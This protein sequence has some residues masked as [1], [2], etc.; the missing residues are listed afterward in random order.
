MFEIYVDASTID[1]ISGIGVIGFLNNKKV[2][3]IKRKIK[4]TLKNNNEAE[5]YAILIAIRKIQKY[6]NEKI[7]IYSDSLNCLNMIKGISKCKRKTSFLKEIQGIANNFP[8]LFFSYIESNKNPAHYVAQEAL[9]IK[10]SYTRFE[11]VKIDKILAKNKNT[12][13]NK[14]LQNTTLQK[15]KNKEILVFD[16]THMPREF[17]H[18]FNINYE[19]LN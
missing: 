4:Y 6:K 7:I 13:Q 1:K 10:K 16:L 5:M 3:Q 8:Y 14:S 18:F 12:K 11:K 19:Y 9:Y 2:L 15:Q 17:L